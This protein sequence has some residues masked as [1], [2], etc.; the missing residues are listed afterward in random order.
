MKDPLGITTQRYFFEMMTYRYLWGMHSYYELEQHQ[1]AS[2]YGWCLLDGIIFPKLCV[3]HCSRWE[4]HGIIVLFFMPYFLPQIHLDLHI[5]SPASTNL[6][7]DVHGFGWLVAAHL[8]SY[9]L[10]CA[11]LG[12]SYFYIIILFEAYMIYWTSWR[13]ISISSVLIIYAK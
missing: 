4:H 8:L 6:T 12:C 2:I 7:Y 11:P 5:L 13:F 9:G 10:C 3:I 1:S